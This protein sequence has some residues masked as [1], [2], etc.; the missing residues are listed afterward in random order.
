MVVLKQL[1]DGPKL[2]HC[3][4]TLTLDILMNQAV[5]LVGV[6]GAGVVQWS[7]YYLLELQVQCKS[8]LTSTDNNARVFK[9][10]AT[11]YTYLLLV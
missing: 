6:G 11:A 4:V 2:V 7:K 1:G 3:H 8:L 5:T 10:H 9:E